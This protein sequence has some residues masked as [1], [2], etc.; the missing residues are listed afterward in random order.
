M[1]NTAKPKR[2]SKEDYAKAQ[3]EHQRELLEAAVDQLT[4]S[5]GWQRY[6][7]TK[8]KFHKYS[9]S[10]LILIA[11]QRPDATR[12]MGKGG[13]DGKTGWKSVGRTIKADEWEN[14]IIILAPCMV[15]QKDENGEPKKDENGKTQMRVAF[16]R[17]VKVYDVAQTEGEPLPEP[18]FEPLTGASHEEY[19]YR[20]EQFAQGIGYT[21]DYE[22]MDQ[23]QGGYCDMTNQRIV[24]NA[25]REV[26]GQVRTIIHEL[27]HALGVDYSDYTRQQAEVI[28]ESAA[29]IV[30]ASVGLDTAGMSV[31]YIATWGSD[32][33]DP[34]KVMT[35]MR[36]FAAKID[37]LAATIEEGIS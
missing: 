6:L 34:K 26:N 37:E 13:K 12:V 11:F 31:P 33:D 14:P 18:T 7:L 20:A 28:V 27:A 3:R 35:T 1:T 32:S 19:L 25:S 29:Y 4:T 15:P 8:A 23:K 36:E 10:N 24:V 16:F 17:S 22:A 30:T 21:V 5:E 2:L 9:F